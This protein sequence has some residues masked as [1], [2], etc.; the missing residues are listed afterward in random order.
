MRSLLCQHLLRYAR[1]SKLVVRLASHYLE[2]TAYLHMP[3]LSAVFNGSQEVG[4]A[5][6]MYDGA[7]EDEVVR[8]AVAVLQ[9]KRYHAFKWGVTHQTGVRH[10]QYRR[11]GLFYMF[12]AG[13]D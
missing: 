8:H 4:F 6:P 12:V 11:E 5:P 1:T 10:L 2:L 13:M 3:R 9:T 7:S